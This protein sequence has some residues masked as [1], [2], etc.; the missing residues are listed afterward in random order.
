MQNIQGKGVY[1]VKTVTASAHNCHCLLPTAELSA[2]QYKPVIKMH[3]KAALSGWTVFIGS[4][5][6]LKKTSLLV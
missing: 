2:S 1:R 3:P 4:A 6:C 5:L